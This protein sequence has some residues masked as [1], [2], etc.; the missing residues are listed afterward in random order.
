M[1]HAHTSEIQFSGKTGV[2][3]LIA[4]IALAVFRLI[5][6][7]DVKDPDV[8]KVIQDELVSEWRH[9]QLP[10]F[11]VALKAGNLEESGLNENDL[12]SPKLELHKVKASQPI[13]S[14]SSNQKVVYEVKFTIKGA[15]GKESSGIKYYE[16]EHSLIS[17]P[18][19][20]RDSSQFSFYM[21][22]S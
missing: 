16:M 20:K 13:L 17:K 1:G 2:V 21:N 3:A 22:F 12:I 9:N 4:V 15:S 14:F 10:Q 8:L 6:F 5:S 18:R 11:T 7:S 19:L